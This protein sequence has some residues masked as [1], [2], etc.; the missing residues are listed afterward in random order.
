MSYSAILVEVSIILSNVLIYEVR[1]AVTCWQILC[2]SLQNFSWCHFLLDPKIGW[3]LTK[4][5]LLNNEVFPLISIWVPWKRI[6]GPRASGKPLGFAKNVLCPAKDQVVGTDLFRQRFC[7][8]ST[9]WV[10]N[11]V[12]TKW[13]QLVRNFGIYSNRSYIMNFILELSEIDLLRLY[14][15]FDIL[16]KNWF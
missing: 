11:M 8:V 16:P 9:L 1:K 6:R 13:N 10:Y 5:N 15:V 4:T 7:K 12:G 3:Q 14:K 2:W